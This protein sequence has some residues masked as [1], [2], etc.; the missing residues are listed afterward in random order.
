MVVLVFMMKE[1]NWKLKENTRNRNF[2]Q[3]IIRG[4]V[5]YCENLLSRTDIDWPTSFAEAKSE[6][7]IYKQAVIVNYDV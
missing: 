5:F 3:E 6:V 7:E 4:H 1:K 2:S